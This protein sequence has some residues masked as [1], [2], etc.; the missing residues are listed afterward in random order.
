MSWENN[1][2]KNLYYT[3]KGNKKIII[4]FSYIIIQAIKLKNEFQGQ[5]TLRPTICK[6]HGKGAA[7]GEK[8]LGSVH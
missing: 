5:G 2:N 4:Y 8:D 1:K 7:K 6:S 3:L